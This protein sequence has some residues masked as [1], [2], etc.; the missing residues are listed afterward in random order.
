[1]NTELRKR[2]FPAVTIFKL[3]YFT[4]Y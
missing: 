2:N 1:M 4:Q 3:F